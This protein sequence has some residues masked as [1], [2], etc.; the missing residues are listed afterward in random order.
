LRGTAWLPFN[1]PG[2]DGREIFDVHADIVDVRI[3]KLS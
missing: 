2:N 3:E 1:Q